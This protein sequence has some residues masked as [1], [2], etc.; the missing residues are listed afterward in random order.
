M[1]SSFA[2][3]AIILGLPLPAAAADFAGAWLVH[4]AAGAQPKDELLCV[5]N[6]DKSTLW[7]PCA[8]VLEHSKA[9]TGRTD[10]GGMVFRYHTDYNGSGVHLVYRGD[11][12]ADGSVKGTVTSESGHGV[13]QA[14][15]LSD[16]KSGAPVTWKVSAAFSDALRYVLLCTFKADGQRI[17]GP[18]TVIGGP[19]L[20]A[21]G[22]ANS[23][24]MTLHF[25]RDAQGRQ[26][27]A[28]TLQP[29]GSLAGTI[30]A[31]AAMG[32]FT[33]EKQ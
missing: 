19:T 13:F 1:R 7:G 12:Q 27:Y 28:G 17:A 24:A 2:G 30:K 33:A 9:A 14:K 32:H 3:V 25:E 18:C 16:T 15:A 10:V 21:H 8:A 31:G 22:T 5:L 23:T 26:E 29:D 11:V 20:E 6:Q 4:A